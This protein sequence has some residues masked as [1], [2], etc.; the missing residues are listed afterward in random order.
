MFTLSSWFE[1]PKCCKGAAG[2]AGRHGAAAGEWGP[3]AA[4]A[5]LR[6]L[7][8]PASSEGPKHGQVQNRCFGSECGSELRMSRIIQ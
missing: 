2:G 7:L 3:C 6:V 4:A 1:S 8:T 5:C